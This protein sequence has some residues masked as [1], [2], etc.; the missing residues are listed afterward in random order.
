MS[1][2]IAIGLVGGLL[3]V[4]A[5]GFGYW[6][7]QR[8]AAP[9][10][11]VGGQETAPPAAP[12]PASGPDSVARTLLASAEQAAGRQQWAEAR[13]LYQQILQEHP[14]TSAAIEAQQRVGEINVRLLLSPN[15]GPSA[16]Y[17]RDYLI[18]PGD[19]LGQIARKH[20]TTL[21]LLQ[22]ANRLTGDKILVGRTLKVPTAS[23][24]V[25]VDKS[26]NLLTLK[27]DEEVVKSYP[28]STGKEDQTP[29]GTFTIVTKVVNPPWYTGQGVIPPGS[30]ENILGTRWLGFSKAGYGIHGTIDPATIGQPVTAGCVRMRNPDVE[31]LYA[32]LPLGAEVTIV[33]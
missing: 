10:P 18:Q 12:V 1:R 6:A 20:Q 9:P 15:P 13:R 16:P 28:V 23:F 14:E 32:L 24:S 19:T 33:D 26:L 30:P 29:V 4:G 3:L 27:A 5:L 22:K 8:A 7:G 25:I 21:E 31:E 11:V 17:Y 2:Q